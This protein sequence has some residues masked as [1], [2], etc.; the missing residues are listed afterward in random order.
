M[1]HD[2]LFHT[3]LLVGILGLSASLIWVWR[4]RYLALT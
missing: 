3:L 4:R 2:L 1:V